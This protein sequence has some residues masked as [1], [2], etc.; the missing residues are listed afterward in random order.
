MFRCTD[1]SLVVGFR[2]AIKCSCYPGHNVMEE[3]DYDASLLWFITP[4][5]YVLN[6]GSL[7]YGQPVAIETPI[8]CGPILGV[9]TRDDTFAIADVRRF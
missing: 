9:N 7:V 4:V 3:T 1:G 5:L 2:Y 6:C 8:R